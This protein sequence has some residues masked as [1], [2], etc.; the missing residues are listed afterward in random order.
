MGVHWSAL[1][2]G[3]I[4]TV[5]LGL[6]IL[7]D[8]DPD[9]GTAALWLAAAAGMLAFFGSLLAHEFGHAVVARRHDVGVIGLTLWV[10]GGVAKL[11]RQAPTPRA[12]FQIAAA[13]PL[14]NFACAGVFG[15]AAWGLYDTDDWRL[16]GGVCI[17]LTAVNLLLGVTNLAP[18]SPLDGGRVLAAILWRRGRSAERARLIAARAGV[19]LGFVVVTAGLFEALWF[20][21]NT[22]WW[23]ILIGLFIAGAARGDIAGAA[24]RGRLDATRL[25][26]IMTRHPHPVPDG[27][28]VAQFIDWSALQPAPLA[29]PVTR[30]DNEPL[31]YV[32]PSIAHRVDPVSRS[33]TSIGSVML[34]AHLAPRAWN[35]ESVSAILDR[36]DVQLPV[37][38]VVHDE[39]TQRAIGTVS[40]QQILQLLAP[41]DWWGRDR[42]PARA[43]APPPP[44]L[45]TS[46]NGAVPSTTIPS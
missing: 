40:D 37:V 35:S 8:V 10:L 9:A 31:G 36:L 2:V 13:G 4:V 25:D 28:T 15:L 38:V 17:W 32:T 21:Q 5:L 14:A 39:R 24:V 26:T 41:P 42:T 34:P 20:G 44:G 33:W 3:V 22:G 7:P 43:T 18:G 23:T 6:R 19:V 27:A 46:P 12:E 16:I 1:L 45:I 11:T 30:W 29:T